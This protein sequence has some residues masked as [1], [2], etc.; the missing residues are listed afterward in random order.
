M[1]VSQD[2]YSKPISELLVHLRYVLFVKRNISP[3]GQEL[4]T[5]NRISVLIYFIRN[6]DFSLNAKEINTD[7][8]LVTKR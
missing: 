1:S 7:T 4:F 5:V 6:Y 8:L 3:L 2:I